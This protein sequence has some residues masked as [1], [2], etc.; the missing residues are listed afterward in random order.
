MIKQRQ[1]ANYRASA[2]GGNFFA[3]SFHRG[4]AAQNYESFFARVTLFCQDFAFF[5]SYAITSFGNFF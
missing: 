3:T 5:K 2:D 4:F 1:L